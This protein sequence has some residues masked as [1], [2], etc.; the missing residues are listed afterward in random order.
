MI[1]L[2]RNSGS[3]HFVL[4]NVKASSSEIGIVVNL[5]CTFPLP[6]LFARVSFQALVS[7]CFWSMISAPIRSLRIDQR[8]ALNLESNLKLDCQAKGLSLTAM[9][10]A[11]RVYSDGSTLKRF[12]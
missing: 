6:F 2:L 12:S 10:C 1:F 7:R 5:P 9:F 3:F 8:S 11:G 4:A